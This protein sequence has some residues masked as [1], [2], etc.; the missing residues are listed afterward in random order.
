MRQLAIYL[1]FLL[2]A[3]VTFA[4]QSGDEYYQKAKAMIEDDNAQEAV[5]FLKKAAKAGHADAICNLGYCYDMAW[6]VK[7]DVKKAAK[8]YERSGTAEGEYLLSMCYLGGE[9]SKGGEPTDNDMQKGMTLLYSSANRGYPAAF[10]ML[11]N[12]YERGFRDI[13]P[14]YDSAF[15]Y[16]RRLADMDNPLGYYNLSR[17]YDEGI[18]CEADSSLMVYYCRK[19]ADQDF[20]DAVC[21]LGD[22]Y[23]YGRYVTRDMAQAFDLYSRGA[24]NGD[25]DCCYRL[26]QFYLKG[27]Q[28]EA[29]TAQA[30]EL[31]E[32]ASNNGNGEAC[33]QLGQWYLSDT[34]QAESL[35]TACVC[36]AK[37]VQQDNVGCMMELASLYAKFGVYASAFEMYG[38]AARGGSGLAAYRY[39]VMMQRGQGTEADEEA[40]F[41]IIK[42][43][44]RYDTMPEAYN[45]LGVCY[46]HGTGCDKNPVEAFNCFDTAAHLGGCGQAMYHLA[47]CYEHGVG[48]KEDSVQM[49]RWLDSASRHGVTEAISALGHCY[50]SGRYVPQ[51]YEKAV[52]LYMLGT[53][54]YDDPESYCNLGYCYETGHGVLLNS[55]KAFNLYKAAADND[56]PRGL[57]CVANCYAEGIGVKQNSE[58]AFEYYVKAADQGHVVAQYVAGMVYRK[59]DTYVKAD[60][61][62]AR[63]YLGLSA[64]QGY[65]PAETALATMKGGK[66][67]SN[68]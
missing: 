10:K 30:I 37:G 40:A 13:E 19:A 8:L 14:N 43:V 59:G 41:N 62:K 64:S 18:G 21:Q 6:G 65:E 55:E 5:K 39:A 36:F 34:T 17:C 58:K 35:A 46:I 11:G 52:A 50:E 32:Y 4:Q 28:V 53:D 60:S 68:K 15:V 56:Y 33:Y 20:A 49:I 66:T 16:Y 67:K 54:E 25:A 26:A 61:K 57:F 42:A 27:E 24:H 22:M 29:D 3:T 44:A 2:A 7:H 63:H 9:M 38:R 48:C 45:N 51:S 23:N 1:F 12:I 47:V 31:L